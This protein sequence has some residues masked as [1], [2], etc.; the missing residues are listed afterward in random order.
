MRI[1]L[2][3][4]SHYRPDGLLVK[5]RQY[6]T[7]AL[8]LPYL[9]ALTPPG[10]EVRFVD[11]IMGEVDLMADCDVVGITVM[12]PQARRGYELARWFRGRGA[13]VVMG[14]QWVSLNPEQA[15]QHC[16]AVVVGEAEYLWADL[17]ADLESGRNKGVYKADRWHD[18]RDLPR[19]DYTKLPLF[20]PEKFKRNAF[21]RWYFHWPIM[22]TR[23]C[24]H[25]CD[26]CS[27]QTYYKRTVRS[28]PVDDVIEDFRTVKALGGNRVLVLDDNPIAN[29]AYARELFSALAPLK[30]QWATQCTIN[31]ARN[32]E[33]LDLAAAAGLRSLTIGFESV[34]KGQLSRHGKAFN[35][36]ERYAED[37]RAIR[38]RGI[39]IIGLFMVGLDGDD[40]RSFSQIHRFLLEN[41]IAFLKLFTPCPYPGTRYFDDMENAGRL[42]THDW[43]DYDYGNMV[44]RPEGMSP[45]A[46]LDGFSGLYDSFYSLPSIARRFLPPAPGNYTEGLFYLIANLKINRFLKK[47]PYSW[48][49]IS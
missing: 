22:A 2:I 43:N 20:L 9:E 41:K 49:T 27:V 23:G 12:G 11:E 28:R 45:E 8:T 37:I 29:P 18:L 34:G 32:A 26:F 5:S 44:V 33:L 13:K 17:L 25:T 38:A 39:Q 42:L 40:E 48:G 31:I 21:Y 35:S 30:M 46:M 19:F 16:D 47:T 3:S 10:H 36:P 4:P 24:P 6:W 15:L 7:S 1:Y 14:G